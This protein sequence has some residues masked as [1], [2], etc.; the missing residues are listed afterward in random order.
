MIS[1]KEIFALLSIDIGGRF[2][3]LFEI[4]PKYAVLTNLDIPLISNS[5]G[6]A[7]KIRKRKNKRKEKIQVLRSMW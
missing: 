5:R 7:L 1:E 2:W 3:K 6:D 4:P